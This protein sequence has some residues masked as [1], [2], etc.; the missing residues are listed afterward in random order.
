MPKFKDKTGMRYGKLVVICRD[1]SRKRTAWWCRC[2]CGNEF[3]RDTCFLGNSIWATSKACRTCERKSRAQDITGQSFNNWTVLYRTDLQGPRHWFCRCVCGTTRTISAQHLK[4]GHTKSCG[5]RNT[6]T[7]AFLVSSLLERFSAGARKRGL[8][9]SLS[10]K[11]VE[12]LIF[13]NCYYCGEP[14]HRLLTNY[15]I[16]KRHKHTPINGID[17]VDSSLGYNL[18]NVRPCCR[19]CNIA[20]HTLSTEQFGIWAA[21]VYSNFANSFE[22][23]LCL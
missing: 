19:T 14:P 3:S 11:D 7:E 21:K 16:A 4:N 13:S 20:K 10:E 6:S 18:G 22:G 8:S 17:R 15:S 9:W 1:L 5:C 2:D 12:K 23:S